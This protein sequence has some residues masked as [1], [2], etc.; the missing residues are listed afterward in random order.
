MMEVEKRASKKYD[1]SLIGHCTY[2]ASNALKALIRNASPDAYNKL[3]L[4]VKYLR[5][6]LD[7]FLYFA[8]QATHA[9]HTP[10]GI[11]QVE[12]PLEI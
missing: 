3:Q 1:L 12:H 8:P 2:S 11:T 4:N 5:L 6:N 9:F 7:D 10:V